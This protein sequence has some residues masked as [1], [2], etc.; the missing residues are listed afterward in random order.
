MSPEEASE[1]FRAADVNL[2]LDDVR[3]ITERTEGWPAGIYLALLGIRDAADPDAFVALFTGD[4]RHVLEY[5]QQDVLSASAP[6]VRTFL[7]RTSVLERPPHH[8]CDAVLE[9]SGPQRPSRR[10]PD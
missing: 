9:T 8:L 1:F 2:E 5:L 3:R 4:T 7:L 10:S 6:E